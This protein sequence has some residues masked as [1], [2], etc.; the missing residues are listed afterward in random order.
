M[1]LVIGKTSQLAHYFP[2]DYI[3]VSSRNFR[4]EHTKYDSVYITFAEQRIYDKNIDFITPNYI[5]TLNIINRLIDQ[6]NKIV[7]YTTCELW[8]DLSGEISEITP[9][10][11]Y[12][13]NN[14]Y[15]ISKLLLFNKIKELQ[16]IDKKYNKVIFIH[17]FYFNSVYRN[18]YFLFGKIFKSIINKEKITLGNL[19][20]QRDIVHANYVVK[21]S[22]EAKSDA[23]VGMG[24]LINIFAFIKDLYYMNDMDYINYIQCS[25]FEPGKNKLIFAKQA[26]DYS[27]IKLLKDTQDDILKYKEN[28]GYYR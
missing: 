22:I 12:P 10:K 11:F 19:D 3:K 15:T 27:Y 13:L 16:S 23:T 18:E 6:C 17:P 9:P 8:N 25:S 26:D 24:K 28:H 14:E 21:K 7:C 2:D 20:F 5:Y 1:N 4:P